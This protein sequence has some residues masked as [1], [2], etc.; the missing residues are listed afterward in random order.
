MAASFLKSIEHLDSRWNLCIKRHFPFHDP[1]LGDSVLVVLAYAV[2]KA[3]PCWSQSAAT[4][5]EKVA[6]AE[7]AK[8]QALW[9]KYNFSAGILPGVVLVYQD[10]QKRPKRERPRWSQRNGVSHGAMGQ[11]EENVIRLRPEL[12]KMNRRRSLRSSSEGAGGSSPGESIGDA[13]ANLL[14]K[15]FPDCLYMLAGVGARYIN[16]VSGKTKECRETDLPFSLVKKSGNYPPYLLSLPNTSSGTDSQNIDFLIGSLVVSKTVAEEACQS[17]SVLKKNKNKITQ[18][19]P[20]AVELPV[21][22]DAV[23]LKLFGTDDQQKALQTSLRD[24]L[25]L[26]TDQLHVKVDVLEDA[27]FK[28]EVVCPSRFHKQVEL[29][30]A[31]KVKHSLQQLESEAILVHF[32]D[33]KSDLKVLVGAGGLVQEVQSAHHVVLLYFIA[34]DQDPPKTP[35]EQSALADIFTE[36]VVRERFEQYGTVLEVRRS[37]HFPRRTFW[38]RIEFSQISSVMKAL[39]EADGNLF[40]PKV[41]Q[42]TFQMHLIHTKEYSPQYELNFFWQ[43]PMIIRNRLQMHFVHASEI[44]DLKKWSWPGKLKVEYDEDELKVVVTSD[45]PL[46]NLQDVVGMMKYRHIAFPKFV[47]Y[48][49]HV[50]Y[51][52]PKDGVDKLRTEIQKRITELMPDADPIEIQI[53]TQDDVASHTTGRFRSYSYNTLERLDDVMAMYAYDTSSHRG[54]FSLERGIRMQFN[55]SKRAYECIQPALRKIQAKVKARQRRA[56]AGNEDGSDSEEEAAA[57]ED[58]ELSEEELNM[59]QITINPTNNTDEISVSVY[60]EFYTGKDEHDAKAIADLMTPHIIKVRSDKLNSLSAGKVSKLSNLMKETKTHINTFYSQSLLQVYGDSNSCA[61]VHQDI[62]KNKLAP[63]AKVDPAVP[64]ASTASTSDETN[65]D[66][67]IDDDG[68]GSLSCP[69]CLCPV[70]GVGFRL[71]LCG[72][73]YCKACFKQQ[74]EASIAAKTFPIVCVEE[75]CSRMVL[76]QDVEQACANFNIAMVTVLKASLQAFLADNM[77]HMRACITP[78]CDMVYHVCKSKVEGRSRALTCPLCQTTLCTHCHTKFHEGLSC[79]VVAALDTVEEKVRT[80]MEEDKSMRKLCPNCLMGIEKVDGCS[81][82]TCT[83][84]KAE[85]CWLCLQF[86]TD[87]YKLS[88]HSCTVNDNADDM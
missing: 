84:C 34:K 54:E 51:H 15:V 56:N 44:V 25:S 47:T 83:S 36:E 88:Y 3:P 50:M 85:I 24:Q 42:S 33:H 31:E 78:D 18:Q 27:K 28:L 52:A 76:Y 5:S 80:W 10:W 17:I 1:D 46:K 8:Q 32:P 59:T 55:I 7:K 39:K 4:A 19:R 77:P 20:T 40:K 63:V 74:I 65:M 37:R 2:C 11:I 13:L 70:R 75:G 23:I 62:L 57:E 43:K 22:G 29:A 35:A 67:D 87:S 48:N 21:I 86:F 79:S 68:E 53:D 71:S 14:V 16:L 69:V 58:V 41:S 6:A 82:V 45:D 73:I 60:K 12:E 38:G 9:E 72:H 66:I 30:I 61:Q 26:T 49:Q 81:H 64:Q